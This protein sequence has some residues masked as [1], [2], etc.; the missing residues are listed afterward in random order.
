MAEVMKKILGTIILILAIAAVVFVVKGNRKDANSP[1]SDKDIIK[2]TRF[3]MDTFCVIKV[4]VTE[5]PPGGTEKTIEAAFD[6]MEAVDKKF[7][8][9]NPQ[10]PIYD[11][12]VNNTPITDPEI[13]DLVQVAL[14][15]CRESDGAFDITVEPL[16]KLWGFFSDNPRLPAKQEIADIIKLVGYNHIKIE[17]NKV[18]KDANDIHI[19]LGAIAKG[20]GIGECAEELKKQGIKSALIEGGGQIQ[21]FGAIKGGPWKIGVRN[22]RGSGIIAGIALEKD[23][24]ISTSGDYERYFEENGQRYHHIL[25]PKTG[26]PVEGIMSLSV[27]TKDPTLADGLSTALFVMGAAKAQEFAK[28]NPELKL[29]I[30]T[31]DGKILSTPAQAGEK[32]SR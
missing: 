28:Q 17:D 15:I 2:R 7:N 21:A 12:N 32:Q 22:P 10:S 23:M 16:V 5:T 6:R 24:G 26:Y 20:Y 29:I 25:N 27:I 3:L 9:M 18:V 19:D 1:A 4:P 8:C 30:I 11:F 13:V 31:S 14:D